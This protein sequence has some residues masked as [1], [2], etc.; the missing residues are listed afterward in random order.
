VGRSGVYLERPHS[1]MTK[2]DFCRSD[3]FGHRGRLFACERGA[4]APIN[5]PRSEDL[6]HG[7]KV[8]A[9]DVSDGS[10]GGFRPQPSLRQRSVRSN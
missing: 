6:D 8:V 2:M 10:G 7:F 3:A 1:C 9:V 4:L 5:S